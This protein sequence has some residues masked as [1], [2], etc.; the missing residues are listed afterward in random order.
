MTFGFIYVLSN[1]F[2]PL[3]GF[4]CIT[5]SKLHLGWI[6]VKGDPEMTLFV[7]LLTLVHEALVEIKVEV[8]SA[9]AQAT[10]FF[11]PEDAVL[12]LNFTIDPV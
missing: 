10:S 2:D 7:R 3:I 5:C 9:L 6:A 11:E 4:S 8:S 1:S 12:E